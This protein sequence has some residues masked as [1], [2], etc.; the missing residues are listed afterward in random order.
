MA[1]E[2]TVS[3]YTNILAGNANHPCTFVASHWG[4]FKLTDEPM[5]DPP[6]LTRAAWNTHGLPDTDLWIPQHGETRTWQPRSVIPPRLSP[7]SHHRHWRNHDVQIVVNPLPRHPSNGPL[8]AKIVV[9]G[10]P[11]TLTLAV[12][13]S[14]SILMP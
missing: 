11:F 10:F 2:E 7:D 1:P 14:T 3:A 12:F 8:F 4:T 13:P 9:T 6:K 5:D